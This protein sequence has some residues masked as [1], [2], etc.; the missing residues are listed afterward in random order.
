MLQCKCSLQLLIGVVN[1][2]ERD[3]QNHKIQRQTY[4][5]TYYKMIKFS[6]QMKKVLYQLTH[7]SEFLPLTRKPK[8]KR[9]YLS[10]VNGKNE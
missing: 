3:S 4:V 1:E 2:K 6:E 8:N 5:Y 9:L 7:F 10:R